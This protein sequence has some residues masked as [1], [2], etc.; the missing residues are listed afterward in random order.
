MYHLFLTKQFAHYKFTE[1][2]I[3]L[4]G[5][6]QRNDGRE[7]A[8]KVLRPGIRDRFQRDLGAMRFGAELAERRSAE[9]RRLRFTGVVETL[10]RSVTMEMDLRL[11]AAA[12]SE[13]AENTA[14]DPDF[15]VPEVDWDRTSHN[16]LTME[17]IDGIALNDHKRLAES[18]VDLPDLG[19][20]VIQSFLRHALRD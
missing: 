19:R 14:D 10:A 6:H 1:S 3:H 4:A 8:V 12:L 11:E 2:H 16:V 18:Q 13:M 15:R 20:K 7:V 17:W 9:A 5:P